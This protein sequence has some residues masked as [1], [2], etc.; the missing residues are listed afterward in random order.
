LALT[1]TV[2]ISE[3]KMNDEGWHSMKYH[4]IGVLAAAQ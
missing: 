2:A 4:Y 1:L 3:G